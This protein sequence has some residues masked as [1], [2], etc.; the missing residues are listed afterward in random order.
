M[1]KHYRLATPKSANRL[2]RQSGRH[3]DLSKE[4]LIEK[5]PLNIVRTRFL[6]RLFENS[7]FVVTLRHPIATAYA[8][9]KW[10]QIPV[11]LLLDHTLVCYERFHRDMS[12]IRRLYVVRYQEFVLAPAFLFKKRKAVGKHSQST[13][14]RLRCSSPIAATCCLVRNPLSTSKE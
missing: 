9:Q 5:S 10:T 4:H 2:L 3:W 11:A 7:S 8:P 6:Q 1:N 13:R 12:F 14:R